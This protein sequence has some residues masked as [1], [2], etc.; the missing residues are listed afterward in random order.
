MGQDLVSTCEH[1]NPD[2]PS[3]VGSHFQTAPQFLGHL[4]FPASDGSYWWT[5]QMG[6][7]EDPALHQDGTFFVQH[8][9]AVG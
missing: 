6:S 9:K 2:W 4:A 7:L 1:W 5:L 3:S 8:W